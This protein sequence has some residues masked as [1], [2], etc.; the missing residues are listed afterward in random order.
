MAAATASKTK[1]DN[2]KTAQA[3][4]QREKAVEAAPAPMITFVPWKNENLPAL[5]KVDATAVDDQ[6]FR[7][8]TGTALLLYIMYKRKGYKPLGFETFEEYA[9]EKHGLSKSTAY[10]TAARV[11]KTLMVRG[12]RPS[13]FNVDVAELS[14]L[15]TADF[16]LISIDAARSLAKLGSGNHAVQQQAYAEAEAAVKAETK[17][18][19]V[20]TTL[21][22]SMLRGVVRRLMPKPEGG[23]TVPTPKAEPTPPAPNAFENAAAGQP[24]LPGTVAP[25]LEEIATTAAVSEETME[26]NDPVQV[27]AA[28][29]A[30]YDAGLDQW[31]LSVTIRGE[32][33][34]IVVPSSLL[35]V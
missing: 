17:S 10:D 30:R 11:E 6:I 16:K 22:N 26:A 2:S 20:D 29:A 5:N 9:E 3:K 32:L 21:L 1:P 28:H 8:R 23:T 13:S 12:I 33:E 24:A 4:A 34:T 27:W 31:E 25:E 19:T 35:E 14:Q 7:S 18:E 15:A